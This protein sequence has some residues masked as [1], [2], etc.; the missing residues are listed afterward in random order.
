VTGPGQDRAG[1]PTRTSA[2]EL[3][4]TRTVIELIRTLTST[5]ELPEILRIVLGRLKSLT[6]AEALSLMLYD[7]D[8]DE[9]VFA[10]T[11]TLR[12]NA[13]VGLRLPASTSLAS[14]VARRGES[15]VV[16]DAQS[17]PRFYP[18]IDRL[19]QFT[20]RNL[21]SVPLFRGDRVVG[22]FQVANRYGGGDFDDDDRVR[23][24]TLARDVG[25]DCEP[26]P[27]CQDA[28]EMRA[29]LAR[30]VTAVPSEAAALLLLDPAGRE[31]VFRASRTIQ[32]GMIDGMRLPTDRGIA[33]WVAR[34]RQAV[35]LDDVASDP[36]HFAAVG[37]Q[38]GLAPRTMICVPMISKGTL[39]GVIQILN[40]VDG[41]TF[42]DAELSLAQVLADHAAIAIENA[43][44]Y[45]QAYLASMTDDL[46]GLGNTRHFHRGLAEALAR[47]GPVS[48]VVLDLDHFKAVV[49]R[50]GHLAGSRSIAEIGRTISQVVRPGDLAARYG[51]DEFV[52]VL[53]DTDTARAHA[54][55]ESIRRA[56]EACQRLPGENVD[57]SRVTASVGVATFPA[58]AGD[59]ES[60]F[61]QADAAMYAAKRAGKNRV[62]VAPV[63]EGE[64]PGASP[65]SG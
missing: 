37:H 63:P 24:E 34:N 10:A 17:D 3:L 25:R 54:I 18:E 50:Y 11:E 32:S 12:E 30:A 23:L 57:L 62:T 55:A 38:T 59:A 45:R 5:L 6:Q 56:I 40:K 31:L 41:S 43:S 53:P 49:D 16:N 7:A 4:E 64:P 28:D 27:L 13:I 46:T 9:L 36:R 58:H 22:V 26:E 39:R 35:R 14:W 19:T 47:G 61:R 29:L 15:I 8:R 44:L 51:G 20:T 65:P 52:V 48:L 1:S 33:G 60:L 42:S 21:L 2:E